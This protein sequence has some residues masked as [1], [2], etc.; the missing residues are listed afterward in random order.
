[1]S[2][3]ET[4]LTGA[5]G[6]LIGSWLS[7]KPSRS[8]GGFEGFCSVSETV[9]SEV[10]TTDYPI[11]DGTQGTDHIVRAPDSIQWEVVFPESDDPESVFGLLQKLQKSGETFDAELG[12]KKYKNLVL[13]ALTITQDSHSARTARAQLTMKQIIV[14]SAVATSI[15]PR[16]SQAAPG[17][18]GSTAE[19]GKKQAAES[20]KR[21]SDLVKIFENL[22][23]A[24]GG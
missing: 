17:E 3:L 10:T 23:S 8:F 2:L 16:E 13:T 21:K 5:A 20:T 9:S 19:S 4:Q 12:L 11:E 6:T 1:M 24:F 22:K 18:T 14:T 7:V 15:P